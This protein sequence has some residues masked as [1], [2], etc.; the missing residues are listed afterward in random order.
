MITSAGEALA[1]GTRRAVIVEFVVAAVG[2]ADAS[3]TFGVE[4]VVTAAVC[5]LSVVCA[6]LEVA[7]STVADDFPSET[8]LLDCALGLSVVV[9]SGV[10]A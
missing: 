10:L 8:V 2:V 5:W 9:A 1:D 4:G 3:A 6:E 7:V